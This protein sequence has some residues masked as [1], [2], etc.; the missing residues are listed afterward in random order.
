MLDK[1]QIVLHKFIENDL[2]HIVAIVAPMPADFAL[3]YGQISTGTRPHS[4]L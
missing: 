2:K 3:Q 1:S 4:S